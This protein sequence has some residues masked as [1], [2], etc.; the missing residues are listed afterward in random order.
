MS[1]SKPIVPPLLVA[2]LIA[3]CNA[4]TNTI[5]HTPF[6]A[7]RIFGD[8]TADTGN[9]NYHSQAVFKAKHLPYDIDLPGH[10][11]NGRFSKGKLISDVIASKLNIKE[12]VPPFLQ[13]NI[14]DQ[15]I[16]TGVCFASA[17]AG[18]D[19][20]TS[21]SIKAIPVSKQPSMFKDYIARLKGIVGDKKAMEIINNAL[22]VISAGPNDFILNFYDIPTRHLE[23]DG[24]VRELYSLGCRNIVV[25]GLLPMGCLPV[26]MTT[27][28]RNVMRFYVEQENKDSVLYNQKL[29]KKLPEIE[30][31]LPGSK[32]LH[33]NVYDPVMDM[34]Q[35]PIKYDMLLETN[36]MCNVISKTCTNHSDHLFWDSI[37]PS[38]AAYKYLGNFV[39]AQIRGWLKA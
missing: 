23:L 8:T 12:F 6:P 21:L 14:S 37:H 29:V 36:F 16:V 24:F 3:S 1:K 33:A 4:A 27:K 11:A 31:S 32:F 18:Y 9:N 19:D 7:I 10:E 39:D 15:D 30:A 13:P 34:I 26:Q 22:V 5:P 17:G 38:E 25:G 20:R 28:M 35:N 2:T